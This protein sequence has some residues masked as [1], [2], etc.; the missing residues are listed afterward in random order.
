[1]TRLARLIAAFLLAAFS[2]ASASSSSTFPTPADDAFVEWFADSGGVFSGNGV[3]SVIEDDA[4]SSSSSSSSPRSTSEDDATTALKDELLTLL[5][6]GGDGAQ[7]MARVGDRARLESLVTSL[8]AIN[9]TPRPF[10]RPELLLNEWRLVTTFQPGT[11]DVSFFSAESW[12]KYLLESGPSPVQSLVVGNST[13]DNV[14]QVLRDDPRGSPEN[15]AKVGDDS[16][17]LPVRALSAARFATC[18]RYPP[19]SRPRD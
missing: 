14:Y 10:E 9:P 11:A 18:T 3:Y 6:K 5:G 2:L 15:G 13:V 16:R 7:R 17:H 19:I 4:A 12:R 1:M 8:E